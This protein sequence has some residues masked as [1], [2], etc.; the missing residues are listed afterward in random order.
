MGMVWWSNYIRKE[1]T[2]L[3]FSL[4]FKGLYCGIDGDI[5]D[6][7]DGILERSRRQIYRLG[8]KCENGFRLGFLSEMEFI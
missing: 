7:L 5:G 6:L 1:H 8:H 4:G 2:L 3:I